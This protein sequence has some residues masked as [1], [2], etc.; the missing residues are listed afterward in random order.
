MILFK[1]KRALLRCE[2]VTD[3]SSSK[4]SASNAGDM[5]LIPGLGRSH[6]EGNGYPLQYSCLGNPMDRGAWWF[7]VHGVAES[8]TRLKH[9]TT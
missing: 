8:R 9:L 2:S 4:D 6:K 5:G 7:I 1:K 3:G